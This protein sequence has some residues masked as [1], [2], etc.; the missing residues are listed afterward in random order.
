MQKRG[1]EPSSSY[2]HL[3]T[4]LAASLGDLVAAAER[5][6]LGGPADVDPSPSASGWVPAA[7]RVR[8]RRYV[9][10]DPLRNEVDM[11]ALGFA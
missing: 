8:L 3:G 4:G 10:G 1:R 5:E 2:P 6:A 7:D 9:A 11:A